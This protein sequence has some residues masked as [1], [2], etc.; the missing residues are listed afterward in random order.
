[1][2]TF[3]QGKFFG[4]VLLSRNLQ[5][6]A[7]IESEYPPNQLL[8]E[9][10]H[11]RAY[12]SIVLRGSYAEKCG[13]TTRDYSTGEAIFHVPG[14]CHADRFHA[15][16]AQLLNVQIF[17]QLL[18]RLS[19]LGVKTNVRALVTVPGLL[20]LGW[21]IHSEASSPDPISELALEGMAMELLAEVLRPRVFPRSRESNWLCK[22][23]EILHDRYRETVTLSEVASAVCIHPVHLA[24]AF[25]KHH[26]C[27]V[28]E[29][30]RKLRVEAACHQLLNSETSLVE[31]AANTGF[32]DQSHLSRSLKTYTG[33]S[34]HQFRT[35]QQPPKK[36]FIRPG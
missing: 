12:V 17:P 9:H 24:R 32:S 10:Y 16:G 2:I 7:L 21:R 29:Y 11:E 28:G 6:V 30:I 3:L 23:I 18:P 26:S 22:V 14:E 19:E 27:S 35:T 13:L 5:N 36:T 1:M 34:P 31:I 8:G 20:Q 15:H 25:R 33:L 4:R